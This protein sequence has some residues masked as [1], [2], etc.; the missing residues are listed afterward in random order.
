MSAGDRSS[1]RSAP[2]SRRTSSAQSSATAN[3]KPPPTSTQPMPWRVAVVLLAQ[4]TQSAARPRPRRSSQAAA[5]SSIGS[6]RDEMK[7]MAS[8]RRARCCMAEGA[9]R[10]QCQARCYPTTARRVTRWSSPAAERQTAAAPPARA[11]R[12]SRRCRRSAVV[13]R[14]SAS[15]RGVQLEQGEE[16]DGA[17]ERSRRRHGRER[18]RR[19]RRR[20][21]RAAGAAP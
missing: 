17:L 6:G 20:G 21:S 18:E 5:S 7:S 14:S 9:V 3:V 1:G 19:R 16:G 13:W 8:R 4:S 11:P 2:V 12:A 10:W 15:P